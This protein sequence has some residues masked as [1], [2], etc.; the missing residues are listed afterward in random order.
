MEAMLVMS[1][2]CPVQFAAVEGQLGETDLA[3]CTLREQRKAAE[4]AHS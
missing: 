3:L 1:L 2:H 4:E